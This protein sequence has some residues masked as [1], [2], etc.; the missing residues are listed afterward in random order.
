MTRLERLA[1]ELSGDPRLKG[2][3]TMTNEEAA[4]ALNAAD[5]VLINSIESAA[6]RRYLML[7][8]RWYGIRV[9]KSPEAVTAIDALSEFDSF[10]MNDYQVKQA[11]T[12]L[13]D[14]LIAKQLLTEADKSAILA[15]GKKQISRA[16]ELG[17]GRVSIADVAAARRLQHA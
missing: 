1:A 7:A 13:L 3:G 14:G 17:I 10:D 6:I 8:G 12:V 2:Y 11:L 16:M 15:L 9:S 4:A 5:V